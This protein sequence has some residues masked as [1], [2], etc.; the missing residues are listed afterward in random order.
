LF[1]LC[2][3]YDSTID[4]EHFVKDLGIALAEC[5]RMRISLPGLA[6][7]QQLYV[8]LMANGGA[9]KGTQALIETF[10]SLNGCQLPKMS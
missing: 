9:K 7:A 3:L 2:G 4:K 10:E 6:L 1:F 8:S 5:Q